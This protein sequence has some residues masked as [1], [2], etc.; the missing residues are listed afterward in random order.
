MNGEFEPRRN[1]KP[2]PQIIEGSYHEVEKRE[3]FFGPW[4]NAVKFAL[5]F[6]LLV[7]LAY[8]RRLQ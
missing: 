3:P 1:S 8:A 7:L 2:E 4:Q 6:A 5:F